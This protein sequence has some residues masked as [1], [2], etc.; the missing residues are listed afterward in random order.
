LV[1]ANSELYG[2]TATPASYKYSSALGYG[3]IITSSNQIMLGRST[4]SV[5]CPG[6]QDYSP[7]TPSAPCA[8]NVAGGINVAK[9]AYFGGTAYATTPTAGTNTTAL[10]TTSFVGTAVSTASTTLN[11]AITSASTTLNNAITSATDSLTSSINAVKASLATVTSGNGGIAYLGQTQTFTGQNTFTDKV[12]ALSFNATS[13]Y[14][15][16][17]NIV[18]LDDTYSIDKLRPV[19]FNFKNNLEDAQ[20]GFIAHETQEFYP[21]LVSGEKDGENLQSLNYTS[22]IGLLVKEIQNMKQKMSNM[23]QEI[24]VLKR[25]G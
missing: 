8:L 23:Q 21:Y 5:Y 11:N 4:E 16:K 3:S 19:A 10:A 24:N 2:T 14:R 25:N 18:P 1:G 9:N 7:S 13:D 22:I 15:S 12:T 17:T 6:T 20:I